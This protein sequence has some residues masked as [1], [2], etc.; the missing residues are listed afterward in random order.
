MTE[1][2]I[3]LLESIVSDMEQDK[4]EKKEKLLFVLG[5]QGGFYSDDDRVK[6]LLHRVADACL[7]LEGEYK[8]LS[9]IKSFD[10]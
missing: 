3:E 6:S 8:I 5:I 2:E 9:D 4:L 1:E 7:A 10:N